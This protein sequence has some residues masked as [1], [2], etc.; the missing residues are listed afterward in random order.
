M[1]RVLTVSPNPVL[2]R[3]M[4]V[5]DLRLNEVLFSTATYLDPSGKGFN[6]SRALL[7]LGME[8]RAYGFFGGDT[9]DKLQRMLR[10][11]G[12]DVHA[13][14]VQE[15]TRTNVVIADAAGRLH[16]KANEAG[17]NVTPAEVEMLFSMLAHDLRHGDICVMT[18]SLARGIAP[19]FY[20]RLI[21]LVH[22]KGGRAVLDASAEPLRQGIAAR[23]S[24]LKIN[25]LEAG[26]ALGRTV[27]TPQEALAAATELRQRGIEL[28]AI[29]LGE[30]GAVG[31]DGAGALWAQTPE[32]TALNAVGAGDALM[33][34]MIWGL[35]QE[36]PLVFSEALRWGVATATAK[37]AR[38]SITYGA[39]DEIAAWVEKVAID[40]RG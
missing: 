5:P 32:V 11:A 34:G 19:D 38:P 26:Q 27:E 16:V 37:V 8:S 35:A 15:E 31:D 33:G 14:Q 28:V 39:Y 17:P 23:P 29:S 30:R 2:D 4:V 25:D 3:T 40:G 1:S 21:A 9:G 6:V 7:G 10:E 12:V 18:G 22:E 24:L 20:A 36:P 13:V